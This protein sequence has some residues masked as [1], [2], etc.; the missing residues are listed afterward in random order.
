MDQCL[1][2]WGAQ[3]RRRAA[4]GVGVG[5]GSREKGG[6]GEKGRL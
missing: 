6:K 1:R 2:V 3:A 4:W 5:G